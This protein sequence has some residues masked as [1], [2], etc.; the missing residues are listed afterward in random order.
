MDSERGN[1]RSAVLDGILAIQ[2]ITLAGIE[3]VGRDLDLG[4][5]EEGI[6]RMVLVCVFV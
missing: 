3:L 2:Y 6:I 1:G 4:G 5:I